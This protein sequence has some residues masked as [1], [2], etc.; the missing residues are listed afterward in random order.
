[1]LYN[2]PA[3]ASKVNTNIK[4][5]KYFIW[6]YLVLLIFEGALRKWIAPQLSAPLLVIRDPLIIGIF[7][8]AYKNNLFPKDIFTRSIILLGFVSFLGGLF[9]VITA[10]SSLTVTLFGLRTNFLHLPLIFLIP[11]VFNI[12]DVKKIGW[13]LLVLAIPMTI[14][15]VIQFNSPSDAFINTVAGG[16]G[17][18]ID[19]AMG[20][21][22][23]PGTFSFIT[24]A[25]QYFALVTS[26]VLYGLIQSKTYPTWL[27]TATGLSLVVAVVSSGSRSAI[28]S[29]AT[30]II[31][32]FVAMLSRPQLAIKSYRLLV[33]IIIV[34]VGLRFVPS[35][36]EAV[37]ILDTRIDS[38]NTAEARSGGPL[39]RFLASFSEPFQ[40][41]DAVPFLGHGLGMGTNAG[42]ALIIGKAEFLLA[43]GEWARIILESGFLLGLLFIVWRI[44]LMCWMG[45]VC[46][47][48]A[49][50]GN[51]LPLLLFGSSALLILN[52]QFGQPTT[53]G[54]T[55]FGSGI[56]L[57]ACRTN[58]PKY[59]K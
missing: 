57:A 18:Q 44:A 6:L 24:G 13:W 48:C 41:L 11:K 28:A 21:I 27:L 15:M 43:E 14:L 29:I 17:K 54:F 4:Y 45:K 12:E 59:A 22:R 34:S 2:S 25:V 10:D 3:L 31:S 33:V 39:G 23:P 7:L 1:M 40:N 35:F 58:I 38:A 30:V 32:L 51:I 36:N 52:G 20:K 46:V 55:V 56:C 8:L 9:T 47:E 42:S 5:I 16:E 53:L 37:E 26:F 50:K 49:A 19:S